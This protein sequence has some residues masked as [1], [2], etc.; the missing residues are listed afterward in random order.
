MKY[1]IEI[2]YKV[3]KNE[4]G[5]LLE[6]KDRYGD[7]LYSNYYDSIEE[8]LEHVDDEDYLIVPVTAKVWNWDED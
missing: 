1:T 6:P 3:Y 5:L 4:N 2:R 7:R 8:A